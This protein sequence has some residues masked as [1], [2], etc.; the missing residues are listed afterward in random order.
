M[1][2]LMSTR[3]LTGSGMRVLCSLC[4]P[5]L[6]EWISYLLSGRSFRVVLN[7]SPSDIMAINV[8]VSQGSVLSATLILLH[9][10]D[11]LK[12]DDRTIT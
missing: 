6:C 3:P 1:S 10:N 8:G 5:C 11:L 12:A 7:G 9:I 2:Y 4:K